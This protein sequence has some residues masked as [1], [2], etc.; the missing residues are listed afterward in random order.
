MSATSS[1]WNPWVAP[2]SVAA[3]D[4][5]RRAA[6]RRGNGQEAARPREP[7]RRRQARR[8]RAGR[9]R[10][11]AVAQRAVRDV[12]DL[13]RRPRHRDRLQD[14]QHPRAGRGRLDKV[15][16]REGQAV[17]KGEL[18]AQIDPRPFA[19]A[20]APGRGGA[21]ARR[22]A[23]RRTR[24]LQ[25]RALR[26]RSREQKLIAA[27]A[28]RRSA[29]AGRP[30][31]RHGRAPTRR[32]SRARSCKL[33]Y[34]R[35]TS[36]IDG[37][38]GVRLVDPGNLVHAADATGIVVVTQID[39]IAV[40]FTLPQDDLPARRASD[41]ARARSTVEALQPRRRGSSS[42]TGELALID[43]Q[44]NQATATIRLKAMFPNPE[45]RAVAEPVREGAPAARR[46]AR[47]RW[48]SRRRRCSA[49][50]RGRSSTSSARDR[51]SRC[52]PVEVERD[53]GRDRD[54]RARA[55]D[56]RRA[57]SSSTGRTSCARAPVARA[58][59]R[60]RR[61]ARRDRRAAARARE[62]TAPA[63]TP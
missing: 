1:A 29:R 39:P 9:S 10:C 15:L 6:P 37:V 38:T 33:D 27:A 12:P 18:L 30:A 23:A 54:R 16:F 14:R 45:R 62:R 26:R 13:P 4:C 5:R 53:R 11:V 55:L 50:R 52:A 56:G 2:A 32:R 42:A 43:N 21:R 51:R 34:A 59:R 25:P 7:T 47:A 61:A 20:A 57:A 40:L 24:K 48:S 35:I 22:G 63:G 41:G 58:S 49:G 36:P 28:G 44:I 60:S 19:I 46:R 8:G 17:K 3:L 31:R